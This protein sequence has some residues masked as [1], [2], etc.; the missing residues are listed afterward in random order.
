MRCRFLNNGALTSD[1]LENPITHQMCA[2]REPIGFL[3]AGGARLEAPASKWEILTCSISPHPPNA[4]RNLS[5][6]VRSHRRPPGG[7]EMCGHGLTRQLVNWTR[8]MGSSLPRSPFLLGTPTTSLSRTHVAVRSRTPASV[9]LMCQH[10]GYRP[11]FGTCE[12]CCR[13]TRLR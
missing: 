1:T 4:S 9:W 6:I 13:E 11:A 5:S 12:R 7:M 8:R 2:R 10:A 3:P